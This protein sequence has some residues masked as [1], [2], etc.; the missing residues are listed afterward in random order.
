MPRLMRS[1]STATKLATMSDFK[2]RPLSEADR[3]YLAR[4]NFL[5]DTFGEEHKELTPQFDADF[6]YYLAGWEPS[7]GG[8]IAW[9]GNVPAG[10][11]WLNWGTKARHGYGHVAEGIP[12]FA[13][14]VEPRF[15][16]QGVG[17]LLLRAAT[18]LAR[19]LGAPGVSLSVAL[20]NERAHRLYLFMGFEPVGESEGHVV[21]VKRF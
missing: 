17:T 8:F 4:L 11:V 7:R 15:R 14:A 10:G 20:A 6:D 1:G 12:E 9:K 13:L 21:L 18:E 2:L 16:G 5:T 19:D 3:T